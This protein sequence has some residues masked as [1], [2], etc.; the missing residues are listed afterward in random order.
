METGSRAQKL[1]SFPKEGRHY[2]ISATRF[3]DPIKTIMLSVVSL[4]ILLDFCGWN[5]EGASPSEDLL[6]SLRYLSTFY[7]NVLLVGDDVAPS[8]YFGQQSS[9]D[10]LSLENETPVKVKNARNKDT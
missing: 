4:L 5:L 3:S 9:F 2:I 8:G 6:V 7:L 1:L 10:S